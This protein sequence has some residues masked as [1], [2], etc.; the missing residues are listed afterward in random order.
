MVYLLLCILGLVFGEEMEYEMPSFGDIP[1]PASCHFSFKSSNVNLL[2]YYPSLKSSKKLPLLRYTGVWNSTGVTET[3]AILLDDCETCGCNSEALL[4]EALGWQTTCIDLPSSVTAVDQRSLGVVEDSRFDALVQTDSDLLSSEL[5]TNFGGML[6][7]L[8]TQSAPAGSVSRD[9][10]QEQEQSNYMPNLIRNLLNEV[11]ALSSIGTP[12]ARMML[13]SK[14]T[15]TTIKAPTTTIKAPTTTVKEP[16]TTTEAKIDETT[17]PESDGTTLPVS[18]TVKSTTTKK[19]AK[20]AEDSVE[21]TTD[22]ASDETTISSR[23]PRSTTVKD[24]RAAEELIAEQEQKH[25]SLKTQLGSW[26][27]RYFVVLG[28]F[29]VFTIVFVIIIIILVIKL[30]NAKRGNNLGNVSPGPGI[31][32]VDTEPLTPQD[33]ATFKF[34]D[35]SYKK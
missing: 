5:P 33:H 21:E 11:D 1:T 15:T 30:Q 20:V 8:Y 18:T 13:A 6:S 23:E 24:N 4:I 3:C 35:G 27:S 31:G 9:P 7:T 16:A 10:Q 25:M 32:G 28:F 17:Q 29:I 2:D 22:G 26:R 34:D 19:Q 14:D 12:G